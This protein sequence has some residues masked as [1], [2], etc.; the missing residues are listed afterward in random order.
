MAEGPL[1]REQ[2]SRRR[3]R[4]VGAAGFVVACALP[5][6]LWHT[7]MADIASQARVDLRYLLMECSPWLL[8]GLGIACFAY[9]FVLDRRDRD[10]RFYGE[11]TRAWFAWG[12]T[13]Y[14]LGFGLATQ[15]AQMAGGLSAY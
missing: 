9:V 3:S 11:P 15:V 4:R 13:L 12:I 6:V 1:G 8:M 2:L 14:L 7:V 10:R 5:F